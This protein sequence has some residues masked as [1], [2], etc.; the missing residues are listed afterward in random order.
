MTIDGNSITEKWSGGAAP[1]AGTGSGHDVYAY[2]IIKTGD[3]AWTVLATF[4]N[5][6]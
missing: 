4:S 5:F 2:T 3:N 6:A 1:T